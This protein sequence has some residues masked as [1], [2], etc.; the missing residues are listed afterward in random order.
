[1]PTLVIAPSARQDLSEIV[2][3]IARDKPQAAVKWVERIEK[4]CELIA[5]N[6]M[7]GEQR[8][9]YGIDVRSTLIGRYVIFYRPIADGIEVTRVIPGDRDV[10]AL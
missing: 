1:M 10:R 3:Y 4:K 2:D 8:A 5:T 6:P 7:S 9:E